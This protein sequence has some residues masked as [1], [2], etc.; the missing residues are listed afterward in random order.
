MNSTLI[1]FIS[2]PQLQSLMVDAMDILEGR[3]EE[4]GVWAKIEKGKSSS[5]GQENILLLGE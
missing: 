5:K 1:I 3:S 4:D 2:V